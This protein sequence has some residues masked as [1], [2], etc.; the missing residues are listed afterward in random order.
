MEEVVVKEKLNGFILLLILNKTCYVSLLVDLIDVWKDNA[1]DIVNIFAIGSIPD[2]EKNSDVNKHCREIIDITEII[3]K[4]KCEKV[5]EKKNVY[6]IQ[7]QNHD[8]YSND[9]FFG[10]FLHTF[11]LASS[12]S[13]LHPLN[14]ESFI[15][16]CGNYF[17]VTLLHELRSK[18]VQFFK[19][20]M[21]LDRD[22]YG[23]IDIDAIDLSILFNNDFDYIIQSINGIRPS[24]ISILSINDDKINALP[25]A[26]IDSME[27]ET[28]KS[29]ATLN[30]SECFL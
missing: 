15:E 5:I 14:S 7:G 27:L 13:K 25:V 10:C 3:L 28:S 11:C 26:I 21:T 8:Q 2:F 23:Y 29:I 22:Q 16:K 20:V 17:P 1:K 30:F 24:Q 18:F 4:D 19:Y 6:K 12:L 9:S